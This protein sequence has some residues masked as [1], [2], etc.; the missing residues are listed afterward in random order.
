MNRKIEITLTGIFIFLI[1]SIGIVQSIAELKKGETIQFLDAFEDTFITPLNTRNRSADFYDSLVRKMSDYQVLLEKVKGAGGDNFEGWSGAEERSD[2]IIFSAG[3]LKKAV[4][5]VNRHRLLN[6]HGGIITRLDSL[7]NLLNSLY[8]NVQAQ[9]A[10]NDLLAEH[11][12]VMRYTRSLAH[13]FSRPGVVSYPILVAKNFF[14]YTIFNREYLR[15]YETELEETSVFANTLRPFM[16]FFRYSV[17]HDWGEKALEGKSRW[18][19]YKQG[20]DY[21]IRPYI[22]DKRS[23]VVDPEDTPIRDNAV[24]SIVAF[25]DELAKRDIEMIVVIAPGKASIYPDLLSSRTGR[26]TTVSE[27]H[28][29]RMMRELNER[30][31]ETVD[32]FFALIEAR[33]QD[34]EFGDS[35]YLAQDTHWNTRGVQVVA[36]A[37]ADHI[38]VK[39][40]FAGLGPTVE[41]SCEAVTVE[42]DGDVRGMADLPDFELPFFTVPFY[43]KRFE[44]WD[45]IQRHFLIYSVSVIRQQELFLP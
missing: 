41:Y 10:V 24:D 12:Q 13:A 45:A 25:R 39:P 2:D 20:V 34:N 15:K 30:G 3:D 43:E 5:N 17:L 33:K 31:I 26:P 14:L 44:Y 16:Q 36:N 27:N 6:S 18:L 37:V 42:R 29:L 1:F 11:E 22:L 38:R 21:L 40:W 19:F 4:V 9:K 23:V 7:I 32:L 35:L 8:D 28:S